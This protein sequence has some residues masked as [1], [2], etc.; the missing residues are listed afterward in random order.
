MVQRILAIDD[1]TS[2]LIVVK[3]SLEVTTGWE[4]VTT[5][6]VTDAL[7]CADMEP[8]D[9]ILL[10]VVMPELDGVEMFHRLQAQPRTK[11][12]PV[13][14]LTARARASDQRVLKELGV[15]GVITKPFEPDEIAEQMRA[16]LHWPC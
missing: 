14:F 15:A 9:A 5:T 3:T 11:D 2:T 10:D 16:L 12:I 13:I 1:E 6:S 4:V 8:P 7:Q